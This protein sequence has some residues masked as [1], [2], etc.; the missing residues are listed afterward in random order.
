MTEQDYE[1]ISA[2]LDKQMS[3]VEVTAFK[4]RLLAEPDLRQELEMIQ[5]HD[6]SLKSAISDIDNDPLPESLSSLLEEKDKTSSYWLPLAASLVLV[7]FLSYFG[8]RGSSSPL[9]SELQLALTRQASGESVTLAQGLELEILGSFKNANGTYCREYVSVLE[10]VSTH[11]I[12]CK[13]DSGWENFAV[14]A[15]LDANS[16]GYAP[17]SAQAQGD[18]DT[19]IESFATQGMLAPQEEARLIERQWQ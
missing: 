18:V 9:S 13:L 3:Q 14:S 7:G 19:Y 11:A 17:A 1:Q 5:G 6:E 12:A 4:Q 15:P 10:Q 2:Y 16:G 8:L